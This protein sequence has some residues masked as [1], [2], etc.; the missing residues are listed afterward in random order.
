MK[1]YRSILVDDQDG[2]YTINIQ[3][4]LWFGWQTIKIMEHTDLDYL[5]LCA[6]ELLDKLDEVI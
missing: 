2:F 4:K 6:A 1:K 5:K 3:V